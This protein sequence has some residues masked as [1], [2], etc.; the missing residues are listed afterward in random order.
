MIHNTLVS[1]IKDHHGPA[2]WPGKVARWVNV[3]LWKPGNLSSSHVEVDGEDQC[4][5]CPLT[6]MCPWHK[7]PPYTIIINFGKKKKF[8]YS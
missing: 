5:S 4:H 6:S 2:R 8:G 3:L 7:H 1:K